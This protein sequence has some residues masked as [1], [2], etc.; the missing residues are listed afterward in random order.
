MTGDGV[1]WRS[2]ARAQRDTLPEKHR[3]QIEKALAALEGIPPERWP[4][5]AAI[6]LPADPPEY[7]VLAPQGWRA[8]VSPADNNG[9]EVHFITHEK[10]L[11]YLRE[12]DAEGE[13]DRE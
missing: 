1:R 13:G 5:R 2:M 10:T 8:V 3:R 9:V 7:L 6:R 11:R 4:P 12:S